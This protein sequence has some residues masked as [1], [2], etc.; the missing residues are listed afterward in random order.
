MNS[1]ELRA[2]AQRIAHEARAKL[3]EAETD[4]AN[5]AEIEATFDRMMADADALEARAAR[6][7]KADA[8]TAS[9]EAADERRERTERKIETG[10]KL[11]LEERQTAAVLNYL[12][13]GDRT[14][15]RA[16]S[17]GTASEG[18]YLV[19]TTLAN[20]LIVS[21]KA[22]GPMNDD[23]VVTYL[24][25]AGG[26]Q[27]NVPT[28]NDT[29]NKGSKVAENTQVGSASVAFGSK[30]LNAYKYTSGAV[31]V[32]SELLTD[33]AFDV[34]GIVN[35]AIAER[36]GRIINEVMT[37]GDG[38]DD[39]NG[40]V[41]AAAN[42][43]TAALTNAVTADEILDLIHSVDP[44]YR[45][46]AGLMFND[47]TLLAVR[48]LKDSEGRY[49]WQPNVVAGAAPTLHGYRYFINSDMASIGAGAK[50]ILF[51]D[52]KRYTVRQAGGFEVKRLVER[53]AD[54]DQV[55]FIAFA[56]YDGELLDASAVKALTL[57]AS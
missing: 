50:A 49:I 7:D 47:A 31:L 48:K 45:G 9:Y 27:I 15:C 54:Y 34:N 13:T 21:M 52:F 11:T 26:N 14:E 28:L 57:A 35:G 24:R 6:L 36:M 5:V 32:S 40:I 51:G 25:T 18:G 8:F 3:T 55:G 20:Q 12:R 39:P 10:E 43:K 22:F 30:A 23:S 16:Q 42:G 41:T 1:T 53:Y 2:K 4:G 33:A 17:V 46:N 19:P 29:S 37:T 56:R 38:S 44:A